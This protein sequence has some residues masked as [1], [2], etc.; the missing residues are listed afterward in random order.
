MEHT[1][2]DPTELDDLTREIMQ[3]EQLPRQ[4]AEREATRLLYSLQWTALE[5]DAVCYAQGNRT[6]LERMQE[7]MT[8]A[9][10]VVS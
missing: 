5:Y 6:A 10:V 8:D 2:I 9:C 1:A 3:T 4:E 7:L